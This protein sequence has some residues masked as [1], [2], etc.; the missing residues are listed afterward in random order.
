MTATETALGV[1]TK[2]QKGGFYRGKL[3]GWWGPQ[4][5]AAAKAC[6][7]AAEAERK[8]LTNPSPTGP[9]GSRVL[10]GTP[11]WPW[12][13][14]IQGADVIIG[15]GRC[16][17]FG[18]GDDPGDNGETMSGVDNRG[19]GVPGVALP[20]AWWV[21][22][23]AGSPLCPV[24]FGARKPR[25]PWGTLV[26]V[27][28]RGIKVVAPLIDNGPSDYTGNI[29][30]LSPPTFDAFGVKRTRNSGSLSGAMVRIIGA[31]AF[32]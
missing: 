14:Y 26:E 11:G 27:S 4:T 25:I 13:A 28:W 29:C 22:S 21:K 2:L 15:P 31:A 9:D 3:D 24:R 17:W 30:D 18:G 5:D 32:F 10:T 16:T 12:V 8:A 1:Q 23:T 19:A 6:R 20:V 7:E